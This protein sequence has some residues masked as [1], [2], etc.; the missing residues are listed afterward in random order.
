MEAPVREGE[1]LAGKYR[2]ERVLGRGGMG[3]VVAARHV[4]LDDLVALKFLLPEA[5][6]DPDS[7]TRFLKEARA[8]VRIK[9]EHV[10]RVH[11]V[12]TLESG[13][14]YIVMEYLEG[15]D[16]AAVLRN[17]GPCAVEDAV[18]YLAQACEAMA[19][20]HSMGIVHRDLK[21]SNLMLVHR[22]DGSECVKVLDFGISKVLHDGGTS[23]SNRM[24]RSLTLLGSPSY[25]SPEQMMSTRD[26]DA[27]TDIWALGA[28][29]YELLTGCLPFEG[30]TLP[31]ISVLIATQE[32]APIRQLRP[33]VPPGLEAVATR[34]L[35]KKP[36]HR[37]ANVGELA[38]ALAPFAP[39]RAQVPI[40]RASRILSSPVTSRP[41]DRNA[42]GTRP[43]GLPVTP[44][45]AGAH[46]TPGSGQRTPGGGQGAPGF[47]A[48]SDR[49]MTAG[50]Q[51]SSPTAS[52]W[53][54]GASHR[55]GSR[56]LAVGMI[57]AVAAVAL[58]LVVFLS[59]RHGPGATPSA[60]LPP[61]A[62]TPTGLP[63][64]SP[65]PPPAVGPTPSEPHVDLAPVASTAVEGK[66]PLVV[67]PS[68]PSPSERSIVRP[69]LG[70]SQPAVPGP[71]K[72]SAYDDM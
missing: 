70:R 14:P 12:G 57:G 23:S 66:A 16:L 17:R 4:D 15:S 2:V 46:W 26:V 9:S 48:R 29:L 61:V 1:I 39:L 34:C 60:A 59:V 20:A 27:R 18:D 43:S 30:E 3:V 56:A 51:P 37:F 44:M 72:K 62:T 11:D 63:P 64:A 31:A 52:S 58:A 6:S 65:A 8:S 13:A 38:A 68:R 50:P 42:P 49:T 19:G 67:A 32:P 24:T 35:A 7:V 40:E 10:A 33:E 45:N 71:P 28:I 54:A 69:A 21:P 25:M 36:D 41:S 55:G 53:A 22:S 47:G 5:L